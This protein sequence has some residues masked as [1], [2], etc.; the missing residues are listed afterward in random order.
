MKISEK[1]AVQVA[2][3]LYPGTVSEIEYEIDADGTPRYEIDIVDVDSIQ[4]KIE[5]SA[6]TGKI[7]EVQIEM[8]EIGPPATR[9]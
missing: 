8:W 7:D 9:R 5:V 3:T 2:T 6:V 4:M 1:D